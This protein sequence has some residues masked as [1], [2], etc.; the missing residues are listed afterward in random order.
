MRIQTQYIRVLAALAVVSG[1]A[2][3]QADLLAGGETLLKQQFVQQHYGSLNQRNP[4]LLEL[5]GS[6][7]MNDNLCVPV[8]LSNLGAKLRAAMGVSVQASERMPSVDERDIGFV[9]QQ[10][11]SISPEFL[12]KGLTPSE[13][14]R[15][16]RQW[17]GETLPGSEVKRVSVLKGDSISP[18]DLM[19]ANDSHTGILM[20]VVAFNKTSFEGALAMGRV[21]MLRPLAG[22]AMAVAGAEAGG[23]KILVINSAASPQAQSAL[24]Q[25]MTVEAREYQGQKILTVAFDPAPASMSGVVFLVSDL[26]QIRAPEAPRQATGY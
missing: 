18:G 26:I 16:T 17:A 14:E 8:V 12:E 21:G 10:A 19:V 5:S 15:L 23:G 25:N 4:A 6:D 24:V 20:S 13:T 3:A 2:V 11:K 22:H 1:A 9:I 7:L